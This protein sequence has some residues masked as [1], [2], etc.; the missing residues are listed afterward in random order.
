MV[1]AAIDD[2][3]TPLKCCSVFVS[4]IYANGLRLDAGSY[5]L[6]A[7]QARN[8]IVHGKYQ[9][10]R[11]CEKNGLTTAYV[12]GRFKRIWSKNKL[13]PIFQPSS[14]TDINPIADGY[15]SKATKVNIDS[16]RVHKGQILV[17]CSGIIG[18]VAYVSKTLDNSIFSH[19]LLRI[20]CNNTDDAGY[21]YAF[22]KTDAGQ[23]LLHANKYGSVITHIEPELLANIPIPDPPEEIKRKI[24]SLIVKS[25]A[26]RDESNDTLDEA[27]SLLKDALRLPP[28][29]TSNDA[30]QPVECFTVKLSD[31]AGRLDASYHIPSVVNLVAHLR[32]NAGEVTN[33]GDTRISMDVILPGRFTRVY[34]GEKNGRPFIGGKQIGELD[35]VGKKYLSIQKYPEKTI[36]ILKVKANTI[37]ITRSG[38][39][40]NVASVLKHWEN[41][42]ISE[43]V[44][45]VVPAA[46]AIAGYLFVFLASDY[47]KALIKRYTYGSVVD[48][49]TDSHVRQI[50]VPLLKDKEVQ[51]RINDMALSVNEKRYKAWLL[52]KEAIDIVKKDV[53]G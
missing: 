44:I 4:E 24:N 48:E 35:P 9:T 40:G 42:I 29:T 46:D 11:L 41:W 39:I 19:D 21:V 8:V 2:F 32:K 20:N 53:I 37:L 52:E 51:K 36:N 6:V 23:Q 17:S 26:L 22:L 28:M 12:L 34:V 50:P 15:L 27:T 18:N 10:K 7:R 43:H 14:I 16:L 31:L 45:R 3:K 33:I 5:E 47:G 30:K 25:Y 1:S 49:I 13:F 38:T